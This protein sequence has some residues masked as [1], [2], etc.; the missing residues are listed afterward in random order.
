MKNKCTHY[1]GQCDHLVCRR[2]EGGPEYPLGRTLLSYA[3]IEPC[4]VMGCVHE[5][6]HEGAHEYEEPSE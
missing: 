2:F 6:G 5:Y 3:A 4:I 1:Q